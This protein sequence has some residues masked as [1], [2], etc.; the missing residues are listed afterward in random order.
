MMSGR[1][2]GGP[3]PGIE[4]RPLEEGDLEECERLCLTVHGFERTKELRDAFDVPVFS[5]FVALR[6]GRITAYATTLTFFPAAYGVAESGDDLCA[7]IAGALTQVE[8]PA[9]FLLPTR[10][11]GVF[12]WCLSQGMRPVKPMTY[13]TI[14]EY[15]EPNGAWI[16]SVL[17]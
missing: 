2:R 15:R 10:Q 16:P 6:D 11:A 1:P 12:R 3:S 14:G 4:V 9:S 7:L 13:M 5:P 8:Q 17:Y